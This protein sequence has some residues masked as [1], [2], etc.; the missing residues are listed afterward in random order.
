M[1]MDE[2]KILT[3]WVGLAIVTT[4]TWLAIGWAIS[5]LL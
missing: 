2:W 1:T 5:T 3:A 4:V